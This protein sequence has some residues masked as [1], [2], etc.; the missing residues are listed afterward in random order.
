MNPSQSGSQQ[1]RFIS[2]TLI[3]LD[4]AKRALQLLH[5]QVATQTPLSSL[6]C[7]TVHSS[8][9]HKSINY[10][11]V[12]VLITHTRGE[13]NRKERHPFCG[14]GEKK[15]KKVK[16]RAAR[17]RGSA[18]GQSINYTTTD[19]LGG[20]RGWSSTCIVGCTWRAGTNAGPWQLCPLCYTRGSVRS[21]GVPLA[22]EKKNTL[23]TRC[24]RTGKEAPP[25]GC[26]KGAASLGR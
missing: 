5:L 15:K 25:G 17:A 1:Q 7:H 14:P 4:L 18:Q 20:G 10:N 3:Y 6:F 8:G 22:S 16:H 2:F 12:L 23:C 26:W 19:P 24:T 11:T 13:K 9:R 21:R